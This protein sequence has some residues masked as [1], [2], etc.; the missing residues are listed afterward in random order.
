MENSLDTRKKELIEKFKKLKKD[1]YILISLW[2]VG[3]CIALIG[4]FLSMSIGFDKK[5]VSLEGEKPERYTSSINNV[6][7]GLLAGC[8]SFGIILALFSQFIVPIFLKK[9][10]LK[11]K[12]ENYTQLMIL[13]NKCFVY[14]ISGGFGIIHQID[15]IV[16]YK[17][18]NDENEKVIN[19]FVKENTTRL[20]KE[21]NE[22]EKLNKIYEQELKLI[23]DNVSKN[24]NLKTKTN[25]KT[26]S[27]N[28]SSKNKNKQIKKVNKK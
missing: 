19:D 27:K 18:I 3:I 23:N 2:I 13:I 15:W 24:N 8:F 10:L 7:I 14:P 4:L 12:D 21:K 17:D 28:N 1:S 22:Q 6:G 26:E 9:E 11:I 25:K 5:L 20:E 16:N